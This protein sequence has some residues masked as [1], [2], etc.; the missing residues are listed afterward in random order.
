MYLDESI[1][2]PTLIN[3][4]MYKSVSMTP[5]FRFLTLLLAI[6]L[7]PILLLAQSNPLRDFHSRNSFF[8]EGGGK[9]V[10]YSLNYERRYLISESHKIGAQVGVAPAIGQILFPISVN[11]ITGAT[12]HQL[13][14]GLGLTLVSE[15]KVVTGRYN[16]HGLGE[17]NTIG[18]AHL[19][20]RYQPPL[21]GLLIRVGYT[22]LFAI[23]ADAPFDGPRFV[24]WFG[25][26]LGI[27]LKNHNIN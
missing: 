11:S 5:F 4:F 13:E 25:I 8:V 17:M 12:A 2:V 19:G 7:L 18:T 22:P 26:S 3:L 20:Y 23:T 16:Y 9:A 14:T 15:S 1:K 10:Y 21:G 6:C 27:S 24:H